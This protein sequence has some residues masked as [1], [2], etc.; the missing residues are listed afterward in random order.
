MFLSKFDEY[1]K[2]NFL[3]LVAIIVLD[4]SKNILTN[5][6][7]LQ[8]LIDESGI[9]TLVDDLVEQSKDI[10]AFFNDDTDEFREEIL[11][12]IDDIDI[13]FY[14]EANMYIQ[15]DSLNPKNILIKEI[16]Q[17]KLKASN[18]VIELCD[19]WSLNMTNYSLILNKI[20]DR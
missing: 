11:D 3:K 7:L 4:D 19:N 12:I 15:A 18:E 9:D 16:M 20:I 8:D 13:K 1:K 5:N 10:N 14:L 2:Q 6:K 17:E